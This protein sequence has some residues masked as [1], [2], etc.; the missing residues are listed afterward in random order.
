MKESSNGV[1]NA[2]PLM[3]GEPAVGADSTDQATFQLPVGTVTF[4]LT[5]IEGSTRLWDSASEAM[6]PAVARHYQLLDAA[7]A[8]H[9]GV[10]PLEQG[11]GDSVVAA[12][13]RASD[14]LAAALNVQR[15][16]HSERWPEGAAVK[17]RIALH[18]AEAHLRDEGN[19]FGQA[20]NRCA[21]L[22]AIAHGGQVVLS[23]ATH[24]LVLD[25]LPE[26][27]E[28]ADLGVHRLRDLG[29][30]E[31]VFELRHPDLPREFPPLRSLD[32]L[33][34]NLPGELTSF[35]GRRKELAQ[36]ADLLTS[37]RLLTLIGAG[38]CGKSRLA[39][40]AAADTLD[41]YPDGAWLVELARLENPDLLP[42]MVIGA[43]GLQELAGWMPVDRLA[44]HFRERRAL[45]VLDNCE[46]ML[47]ASAELADTLLRACP[48]LTILATS[49][50][51]LGVPGETAWRVPSMS[52]AAEA[53]REPIEGLAQSDA[54][55]L[56]IDRAL[57]VR[58][59]FAITAANAPAVA[60]ICY[61]LDGIP[62]AI[63]L[64]A[65]R[66]RMMAPE[67]VARALGDRFHLL[68]GGSRTVMPRHQTLQASI[69]WS[70]E[71]LN[72][73]EKVLLRRSSVFSGGWTLD[74]AEEVCSAD[75]ID[76]Y[77]VL[78]LLTGL[79]DKSLV[80][81]AEQGPQ[82]R[83]GLLQSVRQY[84]SGRLVE[85]GETEA[86]RDRHLAYYVALAEGAEPEV[87]RAGREDALLRT[88]VEE[89]PNLRAALEWGAMVEPSSALRLAASMHLFWLFTGRYREG[90]A[91]YAIALDAAGQEATPLRGRALCGRAHLGLY[92][93][94]FPQVPLWAQEALSIGEAC[95]DLSVQARANDILGTVFGAIHPPAGPPLLDRSV[96]LAIQAGDEWCRIDALQFLG[97]C[98]I[99]Q[100]EFETARSLLDESYGAATA[101]GYRWGKAMHWLELSR[102]AKLEG[103]L[104]DFDYVLTAMV[105]AS[106][107]VGDPVTRSMAAH[108]QTWIAVER[109]QAEKGKALGKGP[110]EQ[111]AE[112]EAGIAVGFANQVM[113]RV[114]LAL[115]DL[116]AARRHLELAIEADRLRLAYFLSEHLSILGTVDRLEGN[117]DAAL[118]HGEEALQIARRVGSGWLRSF[119]ERLLARIALERGDLG[120]ADRY[121][122]DALWH[123]T[124][125]GL[126]LYI[127]ECLDL[128]A[129][130]A[131]SRASFEE[132]ARLLGAGAAG[133]DRLGT[134]RVPDEPE[135]WN[136]IEL[137]TRE[138]IG[139]QA[140]EAA[141]AAGAAME[142]EDAVAY[143]R[144]ARGER[145]RPSLGWDSLTPTE[146]QVVRHVASGMTNR[147]IGELMFISR[148]TVKAHLSHIFPKLGI[149][150]R[151]HLAAEAAKRG[152]QEVAPAAET[153]TKVGR[154]SSE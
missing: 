38:G 116:N 135:F 108:A 53:G 81:T 102:I 127:P 89:A 92:G 106:D 47:T 1:P 80:T 18:T 98:R 30:P 78:D 152:L 141:F 103:R 15:A 120:E 22:R 75:G 44:E 27:V 32:A 93:G 153:T 24:D 151:S 20:V 61:D 56:F 14:A 59:N 86:V 109:G 28:L 66:M 144:R 143:A 91:G 128:L 105:E 3:W 148:G 29:R 7:I 16:F 85:A 5:D 150:S 96:E 72:K 121:A 119:A 147:Q 74:A 71:L 101:M 62:L 37:V 69:D 87:L 73:G 130:I 104:S 39:L 107:E 82:M 49:R 57:Q 25:R 34:N 138:A 70:H 99:F 9:G 55:R 118:S 63:E 83:Y 33:P 84:A 134:V 111:V 23:R 11:E 132:A 54:V 36:V 95:G 149:S 26:G 4:M 6:E 43:I 123:L 88:L 117:L 146:L 125:R 51:P 142:I 114:E 10:R 2:R 60:Q 35:V 140:W 65:A 31:H 68:T 124:K 42:A 154:A 21:R 17:V 77:A 137:A 40:Q 19:Y 45:L 145:K 90:E 8:L 13:T 94:L 76:R 52:L 113:A 46:H 100:D 97:W 67:Q 110:L 115:G 64:A 122:H 58:P 48:S 50:A 131:A 133:R 126:R 129:A 136:G 41:H 12:F 79:V 139:V 112:A